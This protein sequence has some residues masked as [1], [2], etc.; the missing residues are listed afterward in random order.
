MF[1]CF[2]AQQMFVAFSARRDFRGQLVAL[3]TVQPHSK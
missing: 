2:Q 1:L 3:P